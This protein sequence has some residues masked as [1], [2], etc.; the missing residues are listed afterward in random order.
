VQGRFCFFCSFFTLPYGTCA[1]Q[2]WRSAP[3]EKKN[4][5][6]SVESPKG[7]SR[8]TRGEEKEGKD[9]DGALDKEVKRPR[10]ESSILKSLAFV[11]KFYIDN[12]LG[13]NV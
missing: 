9:V 7:S 10:L 8:R 1:W 5:T 3:K 13:T 11:S 4:L 6:V 2:Q 12:I